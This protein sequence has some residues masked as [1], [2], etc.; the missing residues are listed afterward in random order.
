MKALSNIIIIVFTVTAACCTGQH[1]HTATIVSGDTIYRGDTL[2]GKYHGFG[3]MEIKGRTVYSGEW[4][5]GIKH[6]YGTVTDSTGRTISGLWNGGKMV[7]GS[8]TDSYGTYTG[9]FDSSLRASGHGIMEGPDGSYY[10][11]NWLADMRNGFGTGTDKT[12][13]IKAGEWTKDAYKGER[14][15]YTTERIYG[16]DISRHQHEKGRKKYRI[17]W[18]AMRI[19]HLGSLS[20]KKISGRVDYPVSF[21]YIKSTEGTTVRNKYYASDRT[22]ARRHGIHCGSYH[23]LSL[24]SSAVKQARHFLRNSR[25]GSGD[26]PP[27]L[28]V[29]PTASQIRKAGGTEVMFKMIRTWMKT[30]RQATGKRPIL[31]VSQQFVNKYLPLAPDIKS[32]CLIWIARYGEYK[33]DVKLIFWQLSPD[34][35]VKGIHGDVDI[36][37]FN[38]YKD[39]FNQFIIDNS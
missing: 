35:R 12:G 31:Y 22:Q 1:R 39:K 14:L 5:K 10:N 21:V 2:N 17:D 19:T 11:G 27:M 7:S 9:E 4:K 33:P 16:I 3:V 32:D 6:G 24:K 26:L 23:F 20:K 36:N 38:G 34:G 25:F 30:V 15:T 13:R 37:V 29:E 8:R 28:D 18:S